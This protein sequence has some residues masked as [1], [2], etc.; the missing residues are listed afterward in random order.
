MSAASALGALDAEQQRAFELARQMHPEWQGIAER[1]LEAAAALAEAVPEVAPPEELRHHLL[2]RIALAPQTDA[3]AVIAP[4]APDTATIQTQSRTRWMRGMFALAASF[5]L[6]VSLGFAAVSVNEWI[7]RPSEAVIA[8]EQVQAAPDVQSARAEIEGG[9]DST[10]Y[11][12]QAL[13][14]AVIVSAGLPQIAEDQSFE[15]W[16]IRD[17]TPIAAGAYDPSGDASQTWLLQ[18]EMEPGDLIAITVEPQGGSPDGTPS[19]A[20]IVAIPT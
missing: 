17:E 19:G 4:P 15:L 12:S 6:L 1:D 2:T 5:V 14:K 13:G 8:L 9:G 7:N 20:P 3:I 18:G 16:F 11:W 10:V